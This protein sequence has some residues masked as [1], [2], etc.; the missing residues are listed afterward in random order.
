MALY[1]YQCNECGHTFEATQKITDEKLVQCPKC[2]KNSLERLITCSN[3]S[4][5]GDGWFK[6]SGKY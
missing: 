4:L 2:K 3:F 5:K 1:D 6:T